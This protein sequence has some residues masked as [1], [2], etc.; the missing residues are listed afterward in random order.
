MTPF[1]LMLRPEG[2]PV[3]EKTLVS[4]VRAKCSENQGYRDDAAAM[5]DLINGDHFL[6]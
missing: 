5:H 6:S 2:S 3:A 1:R 4:Y